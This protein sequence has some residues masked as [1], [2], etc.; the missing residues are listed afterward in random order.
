MTA[1][2][3]RSPNPPVS[4]SLVEKQLTDGKQDSEADDAEYERPAAATSKRRYLVASLVLALVG[5]LGLL[6]RASDVGGVPPGAY[7]NQPS[8]SV[9]LGVQAGHPRTFLTPAYCFRSMGWRPSPPALIARQNCPLPYPSDPSTLCRHHSCRP[10][11]AG[12]KTSTRPF[13]LSPSLSQSPSRPCQRCRACLHFLR[14]RRSLVCQISTPHLATRS[15]GPG[16]LTTAAGRCSAGRRTIT[17]ER[18]CTAVG[19]P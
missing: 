7:H 17:R 11:F 8:V 3:S 1:A 10:R 14:Y 18:S 2:L 4:L 13:R 15:S 9:R 5:F 19:R 6:D 16:A 12:P